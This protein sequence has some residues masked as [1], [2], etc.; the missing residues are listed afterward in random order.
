VQLVLGGLSCC[1]LMGALNI[2]LKLWLGYSVA[3][4]SVYTDDLS[5]GTQCPFLAVLYRRVRNEQDRPYMA[6]HVH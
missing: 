2:K 1:C 5:P 4:V 3:Y 6:K